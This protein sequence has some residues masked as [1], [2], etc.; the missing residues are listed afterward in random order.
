VVGLS[1]CWIAMMAKKERKKT[2]DGEPRVAKYSAI[3][4]VTVTV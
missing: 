3:P 2:I 4:N 1:L